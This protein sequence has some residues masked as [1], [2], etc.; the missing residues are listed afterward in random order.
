MPLLLGT[1]NGV[2]RLNGTAEQIGLANRKAV[3]VADRDGTIV[4]AVPKDGLYTTGLDSDKRIWEGDARASAIGP[5]GSLFVGTEPAMLFRSDDRG[6]TWTRSSQIDELPTRSTWYF[7]PPPHE[8]HVRSIDFLPDDAQSVLVGIEVGGVLLSRDRGESWAEMNEGV[9]VDVHQVRPDVAEP[10]R[11]LAATGNG[12]YLS[13]D[14]A[15]SWQTITVGGGEGYAVG[16]AFNP[17]RA[18]E[19]LIATGDRPPGLNARVFH[20]LDGGHNW[21]QIVHP[22]LPNQY[23]RVPVL[24]FAEGSAWIMTDTGHVYRTDDPRSGWSLVAEF[25][26][27]IHAASAGGSPSSVNYG[28]A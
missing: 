26:T 13:E 2:W 14:N 11:L 17:D 5:D 23:A 1:T 19:V 7:P 21:T 18:G 9:Y 12:L 4:A 22:T 8:P 28:F 16:V 10:G 3:H 15:V 25:G 27:P 20:S 6:A 24:L